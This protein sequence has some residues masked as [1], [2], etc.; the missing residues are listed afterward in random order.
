[1]TE[2]WLL[3]RLPSGAI[4][5]FSF[6]K[7]SRLFSSHSSRP[8]RQ[9]ERAT[10]SHAPPLSSSWPFGEVPQPAAAARISGR[11]AAALKSNLRS[12]ELVDFTKRKA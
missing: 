8:T 6:L 9:R 1:M 7:P 12:A 11:I 10:F 2:D 3:T 5:G 4:P